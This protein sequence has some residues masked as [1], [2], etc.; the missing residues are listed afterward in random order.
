MLHVQYVA[1]CVT[2]VIHI[3]STWPVVPHRQYILPSTWPVMPHRQYILPSTWPVVPHRQYILSSTWP[4]V[5]H[6]QYISPLHGQLC[7]TGNTYPLYMAS[8]ATHAIHPL[9]Y[10]ASCATQAIHIP[11][12]WPVVPHI[13]IQQHTVYWILCVV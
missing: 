11:S 7:H 13:F 10:M 8:C 4:V 1:S 6:R 5:P 3:H 12:T 9:L 2:H